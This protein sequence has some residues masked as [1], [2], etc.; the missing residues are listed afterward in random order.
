MPAAD[1]AGILNWVLVSCDEVDDVGDTTPLWEPK[2]EKIGRDKKN[3][4][5]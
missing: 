3:F 5:F 2:R 1:G 4:S